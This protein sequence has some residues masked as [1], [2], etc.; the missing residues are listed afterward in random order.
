[1]IMAEAAKR[2]SPRR[3][4]AVAMVG[5]PAMSRDEAKFEL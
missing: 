2:N 3:C 5:G 4:F 1:M